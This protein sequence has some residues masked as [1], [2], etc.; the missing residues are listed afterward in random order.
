MRPKQLPVNLSK[1]IIS[2]HASHAGCD[3]F[4]TL[5]PVIGRGISIHASHAGCDASLKC[6]HQQRSEDFNPRIPCGMRLT[7]GSCPLFAARNFNPRIPCGMR[8]IPAG[9]CSSM[10]LFQS[11]HPMR[12][13]T[14]GRTLVCHIS[15]ISIHAS[16]AG[17]DHRHSI[18]RGGI[19]QFQST[20]PMRDATSVSSVPNS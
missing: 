16:H 12:D 1:L 6:R 20:H 9:V 10:S 17:C 2:I 15:Y 7:L 13:A 8:P 4:L 11:T 18:V 19:F 3:F 5:P 14:Y